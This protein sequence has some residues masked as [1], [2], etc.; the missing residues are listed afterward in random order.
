MKN[1]ISFQAKG[2]SET[3]YILL[4]LS[5]IESNL[6]FFK[7][8]M[9]F[10]SEDIFYPVKVN[11]DEEVIRLLHSLSCHFEV[12]A[13]SE[14][15]HLIQNGINPMDIL[16]GN[17]VKW[18]K[19]IQQAYQFGITTYG[20]DT[21]RELKKIS[22]NA[23]RSCVY[24]RIDIDNTGAEWALK[25]KF[26]ANIKE[27]PRFFSTAKQYQLEPLGISFHLGWNNANEETW[28]N[29]FENINNWILENNKTT[30]DIKTINIGGGFPAHLNNQFDDLV[31]ISRVVLPYLTKWRNKGIRVLAE[32]GSFLL[33]NAGV[34][35]TSV[36]EVVERKGK[37]WVFLDSGIF[38][39]FYW[40]LGG[41]KYNIENIKK[42]KNQNLKKITVCG[43]TCDTHDIFSE[44]IFLPENTKVGDIII[45]HPAGAY[46]KS[47]QNYNGFLYPKQIVKKSSYGS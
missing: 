46:I 37:T 8:T 42:E 20:A 16:Y 29:V 26:G 18:A 41:L 30:L 47:A 35:V 6:S 24:F 1:L 4:D 34:L 22:E 19:H 3:P 36:I 45:I 32:P 38:Q 10:S 28:R 9:G 23:P 15:E 43:P 27:I 11:S 13:I 40:I 33:A 7:D 39:G 44:D 31:G 21:E 5:K 12:G 2:D 14:I 25:G 17:P